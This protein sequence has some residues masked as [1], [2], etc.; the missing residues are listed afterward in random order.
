M[1]FGMKCCKILRGYMWMLCVL[2]IFLTITMHS[3][4]EH[5]FIS[6]DCAVV[7]SELTVQI[8]EHMSNLCH[9]EWIISA[10]SLTGGVWT[11]SFCMPIYVQWNLSV[12]TTSR[13]KFVTCDL[14]SNVF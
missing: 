8:M 14:F 5:N 11:L 2:N 6:G 1:M 4:F 12:T 10:I 13:I 9:C 7:T 3:T